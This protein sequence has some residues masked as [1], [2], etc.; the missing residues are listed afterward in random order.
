MPGAMARVESFLSEDNRRMA[1]SSLERI[2][3]T[4]KSLPELTRETQLLVKDAREVASQVGRLSNEAGSTAGSMRDDT[5]PRVN[6]LA[7][8]VERS[9]QRVG[10]LALQLDREPQ[11]AIFGRKPG[12]PGPGEPGFQ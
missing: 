5:L 6:S 1:A 10:R 12:R 4:A 7:E 8:S 3:E 2:N 11:S 9:S